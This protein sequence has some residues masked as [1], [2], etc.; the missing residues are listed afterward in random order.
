MIISFAI[1][2]AYLLII[3]E[4][5]QVQTREGFYRRVNPADLT[6]GE[7]FKS[8]TPN[9]IITKSYFLC[10]INDQIERVAVIE[11]AHS[12]KSISNRFAFKKLMSPPPIAT[13]YVPIVWQLS[14]RSFGNYRIYFYIYTAATI[15]HIVELNND[16]NHRH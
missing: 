7:L 12:L 9:E 13:N 11:G 15:A 16:C 8:H 14:E 3:Y 4:R 1:V 5:L 6:Y 10:H 2:A